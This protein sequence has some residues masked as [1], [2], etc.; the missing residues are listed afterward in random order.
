MKNPQTGIKLELY[1][2][3]K[4]VA[5]EQS[6]SSAAKGL[7]ISQSAVSQSIKQLE[8]QLGVRLFVRGTRGVALTS[9]GRTL[10]EYVH[11][12][13]SLI[14]NGEEKIAQTKALELGELAIGAPD[15]IA[16][17]FLPEY[18]GR[19]RARYPHVRL[20]V[21]GGASPQVV[22]LLRAGKVDLAFVSLPMDHDSLTVRECCR[23]QDVFV[24][25]PQYPLDFDRTYTPAQLAD[26]PLILPER[27]SNTRTQ[28]DRYLLQNGV[29]VTPE[30]ELGS[31]DLLLRMA[32]AGLGLS[33][34]IREFAREPLGSGALREIQVDPPLPRRGVGLCTLRGVT[35]SAAC[36]RFLDMMDQTDPA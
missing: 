23:V 32:K 17:G 34:V 9:E 6:I 3:F 27:E 30:L 8:Q 29:Q 20:R 5:E 7:Y 11:N 21:R 4:E 26:H 13:I 16:A 31:H 25:A 2:V 14:E 22:E 15:A 10:Y 18:L 33:V 12:A 19:F 1:R 36:Q 28:L 24:A 35:P